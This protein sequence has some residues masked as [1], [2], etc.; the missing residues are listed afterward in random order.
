MLLQTPCLGS[1]TR[2]LII[3]HSIY[4]SLRVSFIFYTMT[5]ISFYTGERA[6]RRWR[7]REGSVCLR[8]Q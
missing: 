7:L 2:L 1:L 5:Y 8:C 6:T 4:F 3:V